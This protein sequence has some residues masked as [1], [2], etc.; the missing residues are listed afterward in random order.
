MS[1]KPRIRLPND[2]KVLLTYVAQALD[3][4]EPIRPGSSTWNARR[5]EIACQ[6]GII[7]SGYCGRQ[8]RA[9]E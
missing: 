1:Q 7:P 8:L 5:V 4:I 9:L 3:E 6:Q 2:P